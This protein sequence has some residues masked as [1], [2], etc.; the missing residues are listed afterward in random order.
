MT[1]E[2]KAPKVDCMQC[3]MA[4]TDP[5]HETRW[6]KYKC[7]TFQPFFANFYL[8]AM[9]EAGLDLPING[10]VKVQPIGIFAS[11]AYR[12]RRDKIEDP[13]R[14][15]SEL[16]SAYD[17]GLCRMWRF[18]PGE[19]S[20]FFCSGM[21]ARHSIEAYKVE[22]AVAQMAL[23]HLGFTDDE[24]SEQV[25]WLETG[26]GLSVPPPKELYLESWKWAQKL[27]GVEVRSWLG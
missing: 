7:C 2:D 13:K 26:G 11:S 19:C 17:G 27:D 3:S 4:E 12:K 9:L 18:R 15:A 8:G 10:N 25:D 22:S 14:G 5:A 20:T 1:L 23:A 21:T 24:L 16:C 6:L